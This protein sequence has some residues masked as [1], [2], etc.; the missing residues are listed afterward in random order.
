[1]SRDYQA[2]FRDPKAQGQIMLILFLEERTL[3]Y[4]ELADLTK[5]DANVVAGNCG[6]LRSKGWVTRVEG[7]DGTGRMELT[8]P[9]TDAVR[10]M[11][12]SA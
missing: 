10:K 8:V 4:R 12:P 1:M 5:L 6:E 11:F 9:G 7:D 3:T 2:E